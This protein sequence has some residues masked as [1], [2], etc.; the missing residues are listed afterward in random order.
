MTLTYYECI[1][2]LK[3]SRLIF[4]MAEGSV[5]AYL[6][7]DTNCGPKSLYSGFI[8]VD[9]YSLTIGDLLSGK[10]PEGYII[11]EVFIAEGEGGKKKTCAH[12]HGVWQHVLYE[13][14]L[15]KLYC[16]YDK[17][18]RNC[19]DIHFNQQKHLH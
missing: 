12:R 16:V 18:R 6:M 13:P 19:R 10:I 2:F 4:K 5:A 11:S 14:Q 15:Q 3:H 8:K 1:Y 9:K 17:D 7:L